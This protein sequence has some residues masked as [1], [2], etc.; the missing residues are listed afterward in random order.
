MN[1]SRIFLPRMPPAALISSTASVEPFFQ[2]APT[3]APPP[4]SSMMLGILISWAMAG[5]ERPT[6]SANPSDFTCFI[7]LPPATDFGVPA[8]AR[9]WFFRE[10]AKRGGPREHGQNVV[11]YR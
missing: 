3:V 8:P 7:D 2:L 4:D 10:A 5:D 9:I 6:A 1:S 11:Q